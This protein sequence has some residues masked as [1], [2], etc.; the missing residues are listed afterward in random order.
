MKSHNPTQKK[1]P[2]PCLTIWT[3]W[4]ACNWDSPSL[5]QHQAQPLHW[6]QL[7]LVSSLNIIV[8]QSWIVQFWW[9]WANSHL[10]RRFLAVSNGFFYF[11]TN[12]W[13]ALWNARLMAL[14]LPTTF[15]YSFNGL[16]MSTS[17]SSPPTLMALT[18]ARCWTRLMLLGHLPWNGSTWGTYSLQ[19]L[20]HVDR[21]IPNKFDTSSVL[22]PC[23]NM[24][25]AF[26]LFSSCYALMGKENLHNYKRKCSKRPYYYP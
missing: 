24:S 8:C 16:L 20:E 22:R 6:N 7:I 4:W 19:I 18:H 13:F 25:I 2:P 9:H 5:T 11:S 17:L 15:K 12:P 1:A 10:Q 3:I 23:C 14:V 21:D 26:N